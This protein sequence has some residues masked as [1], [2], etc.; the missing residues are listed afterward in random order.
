MTPVVRGSSRKLGRHPR[1]RPA[2]GEDRDTNRDPAPKGLKAGTVLKGRL[3]P[4]KPCLPLAA[5]PRQSVPFRHHLL[6]LR[7]TPAIPADCCLLLWMKVT[8]GALKLD[9]W[10]QLGP[11][12]RKPL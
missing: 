10:C 9:L 12:H 5:G 7:W 2:P 6:H 8:T 4:S 3:C 1:C 11:S